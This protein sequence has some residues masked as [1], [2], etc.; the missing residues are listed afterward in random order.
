[1][2][3]DQVKTRIYEKRPNDHTSNDGGA[4]VV[5]TARTKNR[6]VRKRAADDGRNYHHRRSHHKRFQGVLAAINYASSGM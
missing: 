3:V 1:M 6:H 2:A 4:P 5:A